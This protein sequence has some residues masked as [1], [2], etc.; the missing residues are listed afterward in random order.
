MRMCRSNANTDIITNTQSLFITFS[1]LVFKAFQVNID[2]KIILCP[3]KRNKEHGQ[4]KIKYF[5]L[6]I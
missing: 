1:Y 4:Q 5:S 3:H 6:L 2:N